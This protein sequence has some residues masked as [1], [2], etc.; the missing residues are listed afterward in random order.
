M[1]L[2]FRNLFVLFLIVIFVGNSSPILPS[3]IDISLKT[4]QEIFEEVWQTINEKY[5]DPN[6]NGVNWQEVKTRYRPQ[7]ENAKSD[8]DFYFLL[9]KMTSE[10]SD[11]HT[12]VRSPQQAKDRKNQ[13]GVALGL[14]VREI[15]GVPVVV[16]VYPG[17]AAANA[18]VEIGMQVQTIENKPF[19]EVLAK[20]KMDLSGFGSPSEQATLSQIYG[21]I[22][23]GEVNTSIKVGF[24]RSDGKPFE[25]IMQRQKISTAL[26][27]EAR[28]LPSNIAYFKFSNF[29][30]SLA[31]QL[32]ESLLN[33]KNPKGVIID[34]R[35]N[36]GGDL[37]EM[38]DV[39]GYFFDD[40]ILVGRASTR[41]GKPISIAGGLF[42]IPLEVYT[43]KKGGQ[44]YA[45]KVV[46]LTNERSGS[47]SETFAA[48]MQENNRAK[49]I[50]NKT[51]GCALIV[52]KH[53]ELKGGGELDISEVGGLT[54][55][56]KKL[57]G[58]G[59]TPDVLIPLTL[60]D[61]QNSNDKALKEAERE[62]TVGTGQR[63]AEFVPAD[64]EIYHGNLSDGVKELN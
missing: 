47:A 37:E 27:F 53:R 36:G 17:S 7:I 62:L 57:E 46:I 22:F 42:K 63:T 30:K 55:K 38:L 54:A 35:D 18:G 52:L 2:R 26:Q 60:K 59:V 45:G 5:Y 15:E 4:R 14:T 31:K 32:K 24:L 61:L 64:S 41:T 8:D 12:L 23:G 16:R 43:G 9:R 11:S 50:G 34:L 13:Q 49:I 6:F 51:C 56:G 19:S 28:L 20:A 44:V 58:N 48:A 40:K 21:K 33:F 29:R 1:K 10:L 39:L 25:A 3:P